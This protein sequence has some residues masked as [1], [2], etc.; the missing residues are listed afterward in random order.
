[1]STSGRSF[2]R[3]ETDGT[4]PPRRVYLPALLLDEYR[5]RFPLGAPLRLSLVGLAAA[6][7][8]RNGG[9]PRIRFGFVG[10]KVTRANMWAHMVPVRLRGSRHVRLLIAEHWEV[11]PNPPT[12]P[13][14][15]P[16]APSLRPR[17]VETPRRPPGN[18]IRKKGLRLC[19]LYFFE[20]K[21]SCL[22]SHL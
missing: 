1:M 11:D 18:P 21:E 15:A 14:P 2:G 19:D 17:N 10:R 7:R 22:T 20:H 3:M 4:T 16:R 13:E 6:A 12:S 8:R 9:T 5:A